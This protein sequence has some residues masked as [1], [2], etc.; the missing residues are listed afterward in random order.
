M[1]KLGTVDVS[2][3]MRGKDH[4]VTSRDACEMLYSTREM[5]KH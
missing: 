2:N 1:P 4:D 5:G 3:V